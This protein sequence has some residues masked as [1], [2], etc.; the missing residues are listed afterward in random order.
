MKIE[1]LV[2]RNNLIGGPV[3]WVNFLF[4]LQIIETTDI[5]RINTP[6]DP[7][8]FRIIRFS[9]ENIKN[10]ADENSP[11]AWGKRLF[12]ENDMPDLNQSMQKIRRSF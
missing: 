9:G 1:F 11:V 6:L 3:G 2:E 7:D 10:I 12:G 8:G 4:S 5:K